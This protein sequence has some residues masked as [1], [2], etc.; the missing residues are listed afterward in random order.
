M[1]H[2]Q[3]GGTERFLNQI[4]SA[5][6]E[7]GHEVTI[8]CRSHEEPSHPATQF[9]KL[10]GFAPGRGWRLWRFAK[11]VEHHIQHHHYDLVFGL[12]RTWSQDVIR[13]G[14]GLYQDQIERGLGYRRFWPKDIIAN[15]IEQRAFTPGNYRRVIANSHLTEQTLI[16]RYQIPEQ[17]IVT[18]H[19]AVD[20]AKFNPGLR[21][22]TGAELRASCGFTEQHNVYLFLGSGYR[23]KGL[24]RL[25]KAFA[26]LTA[27]QPQ[28]RL[29][30]VGYDGHPTYYK[31]QAGRL[32]LTDKVA[33]L[34]GRRDVDVC[35]NAADCYVLPTR[36]DAF[37]FSVLEALACGLPVVVTDS[38]G[39]AEVV[40]DSAGEVVASADEARLPDRLCAAMLAAGNGAKDPERR[41]MARTVAEHYDTASVMQRNIEVLQ[42]VA[43]EKQIRRNE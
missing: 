23:R 39:A 25:L 20:I 18:I 16:K 41:A 3:V 27:Q 6:L 2:A 8:L 34:G 26:L 1:R 29:M 17:R 22:T 30:V 33:F 13:V 40:T 43:K 10:T 32:R 21:S 11:A 28:A 5:L 14:G 36:F 24:D 31:E 7:Q 37:G 35:Y 19:N 4:S 38:A 15:L 12:G 42:A 9:V